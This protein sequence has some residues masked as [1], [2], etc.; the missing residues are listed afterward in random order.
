MARSGANVAILTPSTLQVTSQ[1]GLLVPAMAADPLRTALQNLNYLWRQYR[2]P[3][4]DLCPNVAVTG[5]RAK[6][7]YPIWPSQDGIKYNVEHRLMPSWTTTATITVDYCT[8][9]TGGT[10][11]WTN[12]ATSSTATTANVLLTKL[13]NGLVIPANAVALRFDYQVALGTCAAEHVLVYPAADACTV[14]IKPSGFVPFDDGMLAVAGAPIH[15]ELLNRCKR[16]TLAIVRDRRQQVLSFGQVETGTTWTVCPPDKAP[17]DAPA[18]YEQF[19]DLP[20]VRIW[21]PYQ[22]PTVV[23]ALRVL[24]DVDAGATA[25]LIRV[26]QLG[27]QDAQSIS[28]SASG[29]IVSGTLRLNLQGQG[30]SR[31]ADIAIAAR[32]TTGNS[33]RLRAVS[34]YWTPGD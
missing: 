3:L 33:T 32:R 12:L 25:D 8:S 23:V 22:G 31:Y 18:S 19:R 5:G 1:A 29:A 26:R 28:F 27:V 13:D 7:V 14:G 20:A 11:T 24:A 6:L 15:T 10:T 2:P 17:I 16:S 9:Y 21:L 30:L 34:A 4:V